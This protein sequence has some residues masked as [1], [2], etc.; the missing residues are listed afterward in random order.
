MITIEDLLALSPELRAFGARPEMDPLTEEDALQEAQLLDVRFDALRSTVGL[1]F[2]LRL[3]LQLREGNTGVL[4]AHGVRDL[5]WTAGSRSTKLTAWTVGG[6]TPQ[7][8]N[9]MFG[10]KF[11]MWPE[12]GAQLRLVAQRA[13]FFTGDVPHLADAPPNY[14][15]D[16]DSTIRAGLANW[17]SKFVP[18]HA[19]FLDPP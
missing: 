4:V 1:L 6:S 12:P 5:S 10:L 17:R 19:V 9:N 3:A 8:R 16:D 14:V 18:I 2:E 7:N 11:G 13:A 15:E